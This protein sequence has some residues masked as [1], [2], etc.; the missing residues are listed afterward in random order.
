MPHFFWPALAS[1]AHA[2]I[3]IS[4]SMTSLAHS[5]PLEDQMGLAIATVVAAV[6]ACIVSYIHFQVIFL[7]F[8]YVPLSYDTFEGNI[9]IK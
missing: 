7:S 1:F 5:Q 2:T 6:L 9:V 8:L 3:C 4:L